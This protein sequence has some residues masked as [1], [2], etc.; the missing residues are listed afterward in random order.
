MPYLMEIIEEPMTRKTMIH[1][2]L[3]LVD[4]YDKLEKQSNF[5]NLATAFLLLFLLK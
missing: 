3:L 1:E 4:M 2:V 5:Q